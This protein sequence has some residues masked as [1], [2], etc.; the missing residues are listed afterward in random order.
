MNVLLLGCLCLFDKLTPSDFVSITNSHSPS[1][2][3]RPSGYSGMMGGDWTG[4]EEVF[5]GCEFEGSFC[6]WL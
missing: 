2:L 3:L 1:L 5:M 4:L 6:I